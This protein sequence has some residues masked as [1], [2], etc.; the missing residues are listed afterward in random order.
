MTLI[1]VVNDD[2][3]FI[4]LMSELL[5]DEGYDTITH[6]VGH[7][8]Y[9]MLKQRQPDL[10]VLDIRMENPDAGWVVL[11][12]MRLDPVTTYIPVVICSADT[13][14]LQAKATQLQEKGCCVL[15]KPFRLD[16]LLNIVAGALDPTHDAC[17]K[18]P[19]S[20]V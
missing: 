5:Q 7:T 13:Q 16:D 18:Q 1:A 2:T 20:L 15:E 11:D 9:A 6:K 17:G 4:D 14:F 19:A 12:L 10:V 8:A 3:T